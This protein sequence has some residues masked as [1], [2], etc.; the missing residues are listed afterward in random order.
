MAKY[1]ERRYVQPKQDDSR[2]R[3]YDAVRTRDL[4]ALLQLYAEGEDLAKPAPIP[5]GLVRC[6]SLLAGGSIWPRHS[7][8]IPPLILCSLPFQS[9][10]GLSIPSFVIC[11]GYSSSFSCFKA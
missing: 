4:L 7:D 3:V 9:S 6:R 8:T 10:A 5:E 11:L 1:V 2:H